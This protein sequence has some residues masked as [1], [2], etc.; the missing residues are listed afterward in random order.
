MLEK[1]LGESLPRDVARLS[2]KELRAV[3]RLGMERSRS[4]GGVT[5][6]DMYL[7][8]TMMFMLGSYFD[9][10]RQLAWA[11][12]LLSRGAAMAAVHGQALRYLDAV[13]GEENE[14][15]IK[16]LVRVGRLGLA[17]L[18]EA[19]AADFEPR[20]Q[21]LLHA[22]YPTKYNAQ[23]EK[24]NRELVQ[25]GRAQA[26]QYTMPGAGAALLAG[27]AFLLGAGFDRDPVHPWI[28]SVL[29]QPGGEAKVQNVYRRSLEFV[30]MSLR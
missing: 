24:A 30:A 18:P 15:L 5:V 13:A 21:T 8:L 1:C 25:L 12:E 16:T 7:Y 28:Q 23:S 22:I 2:G 14:H 19:N 20:M 26:S 11:K 27:M 17:Q 6:R 3:V 29:G 10:D 4:H 9:E